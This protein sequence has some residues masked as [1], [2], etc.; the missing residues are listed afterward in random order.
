MTQSIY[1][2]HIS[3]PHG[4]SSRDANLITVTL[5]IHQWLTTSLKMERQKE[6]WMYAVVHYYTFVTN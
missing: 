3:T 6:D 5:T 2:I 1:I 4:S